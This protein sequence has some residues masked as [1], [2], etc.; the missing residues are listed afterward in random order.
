MRPRTTYALVA[1]LALALAIAAAGCGG[2]ETTGSGEPFAPRASLSAVGGTKRTDKPSFVLRVETRPADA[3]I[4]TVSVSLPPVTLV[5]TTSL[6]S[7]CTERDLR[8]DRC[9]GKKRLGTARALSPA[10]GGPLAGPVYAVTG[11]GK[12]PRL[13]YVLN[14]GPAS[15][16][17]RGRIL[18]AGGRIGAS[19]EDIPDVPLSSFELVVDGGKGGYLV[20]SRDICRPAAPA[21]AVFTSQAG[22]TFER[23]VPLEAGCGP[24]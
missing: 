22:D 18:S 1:T 6:G 15:I 2:S 17:L 24:S 14:N 4:R 3:R 21:D 10:Y 13:A 16:L 9:A 7:F 23:K 8:A 20:L 5:D 12:L 11:S 19:V